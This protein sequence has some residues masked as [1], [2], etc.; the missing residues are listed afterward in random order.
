MFKRSKPRS[1]GQMASELVYPPGGFRRSTAYLWHRLRRLPDQPHRI[2]RGMAAGVFLSFTPLHGFHF[3]VAALVSL[4]IRGNVLAAFVGTFAGNPL[5]TPFIALAAVGLGRTLLGLP[6]DMSPQMIFREFA[7]ATSETWQ[8]I[9]SAIGP[10]PTSWS[11]LAEFWHEIFLPYAVGGAV[12]GAFAA[13]G[14]YYL[15]IPLVRRYHRRKALAMA[16]R[17][18]RVQGAPDQDRR[19]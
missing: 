6:G 5:T 15:T 18:A 3:I 2:A 14:A 7:H 12:L 17:I 1:Y 8:N 9:V 4:A 13:V 11:G 10:G 19:R 16:K